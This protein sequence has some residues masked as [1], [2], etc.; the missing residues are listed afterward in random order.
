VRG[1]DDFPRAL[2]AD[3][4]GEAG[5]VVLGGL[6]EVVNNRVFLV[7]GDACFLDEVGPADEFDSQL[8]A[9]PFGDLDFV[10]GALD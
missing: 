4:G 3:G 7:F 2:A 9:F 8:E 6:F 10:L 1:D 5:Q